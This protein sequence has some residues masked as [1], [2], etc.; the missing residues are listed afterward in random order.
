MEET[1]NEDVGTINISNIA[2]K[3][4]WRRRATSE[5]RS[6]FR[7]SSNANTLYPMDGDRGTWTLLS[8]TDL[9]NEFHSGSHDIYHKFGV[10]LREK[11]AFEEGKGMI[12]DGYENTTQSSNSLPSAITYNKVSHSFGAPISIRGVGDTDQDNDRIKVVKRY[13]EH[14]MMHNALLLAA[15]AMF[16]F[17]DA[18]VYIYIDTDRKLKY[19]VY[20]FDEGDET[21]LRKNYVT[22]EEIGVRKFQIDGRSAVELFRRDRIELWVEDTDPDGPLSSIF[23]IRYQALSE[24]G[25]RLA[26]VKRNIISELPFIYHREPDSC[27]GPV[28]NNINDLDKLQSDLLESGLYFAY[29]YLFTKGQLIDLPSAGTPGKA[30]GASDANG[31]A[32]F[33]SP[34][35]VSN[36][37]KTN[38]ENLW[39]SILDGT[40]SVI[41]R[42]ESLKGSQD[43]AS[44]IQLLYA[45]EFKWAQRAYA[46]MDDFFKRFLS[47]FKEHVGILEGDPEGYR[48]LEIT[49]E[50]TPDAPKN[51]AAETD[52]LVKKVE[53]GVMSQETAVE[54]IEGSSPAELKRLELEGKRAGQQEATENVVEN[55]V[56][57]E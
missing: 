25:Y 17:G 10:S 44:F 8:Q 48:A 9:L 56:V 11:W 36:I 54:S 32:K 38:W 24:D 49:Y 1:L 3:P 22:G 42:P 28:M 7:F 46:R 51:Q 21:T 20:R 16:G 39:N 5:T 29:P 26:R 34:P 19:K 12:F 45:P 53:V 50:L 13:W 2:M 6:P 30:F 31:D 14:S 47:A 37:Y 23:D 27:Y 33:L 35:D 52:A 57:T 18:A 15:E 40:Q 55:L 4:R 41:I 43:S